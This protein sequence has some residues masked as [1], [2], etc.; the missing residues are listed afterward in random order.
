MQVIP[1]WH[2][3]AMDLKS[4][5]RLLEKSSLS[6]VFRA[7]TRDCAYPQDIEYETPFIFTI[8]KGLA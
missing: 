5:P 6:E 7:L 8:P 4:S 1:R 2:K 3:S